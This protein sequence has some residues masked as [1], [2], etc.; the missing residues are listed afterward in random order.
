MWRTIIAILV[1]SVLLGP[2]LTTRAQTP[3]ASG[4]QTTTPESQGLDSAALAKGLQAIRDS[5]MPLHS[6]MIAR[7]DKIRLDAYF[8]PYDGA[9]PHDLAS[10]TKGVTTTLIGIAIDQKLLTLDD[11]SL[12][13]F[14]DR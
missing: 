5:G 14:P 8:Y 6:L 1:A 10:V 13:F 9:D 4:W 12:S 7:N 11:P 2:V 3:I